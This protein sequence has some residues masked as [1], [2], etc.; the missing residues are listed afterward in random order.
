MINFDELDF[1]SGNQKQWID[2]RLLS[3]NLAMSASYEEKSDLM[4]SIKYIFKVFYT[5]LILDLV[6]TLQHPHSA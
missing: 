2:C 1:Y 3:F 6:E 5:F 4:S